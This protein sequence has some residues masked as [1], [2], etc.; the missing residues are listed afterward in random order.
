MAYPIQG[1]LNLHEISFKMEPT[2]VKPKR[3]N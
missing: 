1:F 2:Q 3:R